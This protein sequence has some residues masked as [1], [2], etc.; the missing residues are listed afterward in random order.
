MG[1]FQSTAELCPA[2]VALWTHLLEN[3]QRVRLLYEVE[4]N[5]RLEEIRVRFKRHIVSVD[6]VSTG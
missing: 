5:S 2:E 1:V 6:Y 3:T 4:A